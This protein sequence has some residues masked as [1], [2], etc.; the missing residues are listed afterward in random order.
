MMLCLN[1]INILF[2]HTTTTTKRFSFAG[3]QPLLFLLTLAVRLGGV[4]ALV[5]NQVL[6]LVVFATREVRVENSLGASS[7]SFL[8]IDG[9]SG[10]V[11][12][13]GVA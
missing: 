12:D 6:R 7:I 11:G 4:V 5:D 8:R 13:H 1:L 9:R 10:H 2:L 3:Y